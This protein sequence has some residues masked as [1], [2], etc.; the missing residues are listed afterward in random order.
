MILLPSGILNHVVLPIYVKAIIFVAVVS[1]ALLYPFNRFLSNLFAF[2]LV[3]FFANYSD[4]VTRISPKI[5]IYYF[6]SLYS[7]I[8]LFSV[9]L[10][11]SRASIANVQSATKEKLKKFSWSCWSKKI[12]A[13]STVGMFCGLIP[14]IGSTISSYMSYGIEKL[15]GKS[16]LDR[17]AASETANNSAIITNWI[18]LLIFGVPITSIEIVFLQY[19]NLKGIK[20]QSL[21][22]P[23]TIL[24]FSLLGII[25]GIIYFYIALK[26]NRVFYQKLGKIVSDIKFLILLIIISLVSYAVANNFS[27]E[28]VMAHLLVFLPIGWLFYKLSSNLLVITVGL[29][30]SQQI[31]FTLM[32]LYQIYF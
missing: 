14:Q 18:P 22:I 30:L 6:D 24:I 21:L 28:I 2:L 15:R 27:W 26:T 7:L 31:F 17:I 19:F 4:I 29:L 9:M 20:L 32:Q 25:A 3:C 11:L 23:Q 16:S 13:Y 8:I 5:P 12:I 10:L 1:I